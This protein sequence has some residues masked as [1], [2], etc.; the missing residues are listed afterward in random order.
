MARSLTVG[1]DGIGADGATAAGRVRSIGEAAG[2]VPDTPS[3]WQTSSVTRT[4]DGCPRRLLA[5][6]SRPAARSAVRSPRTVARRG[7]SEPSPVTSM[8][9]RPLPFPAFR[10]CR[11]W[12]LATVCAV[13]ALLPVLPG[14][15]TVASLGSTLYSTSEA[16]A[17]AVK[18]AV[19]ERDEGSTE[20]DGQ[21][22]DRGGE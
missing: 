7:N 4:L 5:V 18:D 3:A 1:M 14:C 12:R 16:I 22:P 6:S 15:G 10:G 17:T 2:S 21:G 9:D 19:K 8:R 20:A 13:L 11:P